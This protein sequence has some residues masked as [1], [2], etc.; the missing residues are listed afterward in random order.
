MGVNYQV[1]MA[2]F[3][4]SR[5]YRQFQRADKAFWKEH[6]GTAERHLKKALELLATAYDHM[7]KAEEDAI[8]K[9]GNEIGKGND[10]LDKCINALANGKEDHAETQYEKALEHY[11]KALDLVE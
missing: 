10:E 11:S 9:A 3:D 5:A 6:D 4:I 2:G 8:V 1:N 7:V